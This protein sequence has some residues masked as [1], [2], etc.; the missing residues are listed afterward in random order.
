MATVTANLGLTQP[1]YGDSG[2]NTTLNT[3]AS[4]LDAAINPWFYGTGAPGT[5]TGQTNNSFYLDTNALNLYKRVAGTWTLVCGFGDGSGTP[6]FYGSGAP[7]TITGQ[8]NGSFYLD[9]AALNLYTLISGTWTIVCGF[10]SESGTPWFYGT[11]APGTITGQTNNSFYLDTAALNLYTLLS[12]TWTLV[13]ALGTPSDGY[14]EGGE[15]DLGYG[16]TGSGGSSGTPPILGETPS[17]LVNG[18]NTTYTTAGVPYNGTDGVY[19]Q[20][21]RLTRG[22]DYTISS[23]TWTLMVAPATGDTLRMDYSTAAPSILPV[24]GETPSGAVNGTNTAYTTA[25]TPSSGTDAAYLQG[26]RLTRGIDYTL[27]GNTWNLTV[28]PATGDTLRMDYST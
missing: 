1:A 20:G 9:T 8:T 4:I 27:S 5:I 7:G 28:A 18:S 16:G 15:G 23:S 14:G 26:I 24:M 13:C 11:G 19:L 3:N 21:I 6:W 25:G 10:A 17:G 12:G 2:W 22:I